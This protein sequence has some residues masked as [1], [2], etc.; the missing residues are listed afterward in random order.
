MWN[1]SRVPHKVPA[2]IAILRRYAVSS[3]CRTGRVRD[4]ALVGGMRPGGRPEGVPS[5][6]AFAFGCCADSQPRWKG[7][8]GV[9][10]DAPIAPPGTGLRAARF[11]KRV[12]G[13]V[14][15]PHS[16]HLTR[17]S[18]GDSG[19]ATAS[20]IVESRLSGATA[21]PCAPEVEP[22]STPATPLESFRSKW[23][24]RA[25]PS[26]GQARPRGHDTVAPAR[27]SAQCL[28]AQ[29][30]ESPHHLVACHETGLN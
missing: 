30:C 2:C 6:G 9:D 4:L 23:C 11:P 17:A 18:W 22:L 19:R 20:L 28:G 8:R 13:R 29:R 5:P 12:P 10:H 24:V 21:V 15:H 27:A 3:T 25:I 1:T 16:S 26:C 14:F 7:M